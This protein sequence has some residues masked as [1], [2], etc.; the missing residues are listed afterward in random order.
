MASMAFS[1]AAFWVPRLKASP[2]PGILASGEFLATRKPFGR[3]GIGAGEVD[4]LLAVLGDAHAGHD[5]VVLLGVERRNDA[6]PILRHDLALHLHAAAE[7]AG[8]IDLEAFELAASAGEVPRR[9][10]AFRGDL[11]GLALRRRA[12]DGERRA[13]EGETDSLE[14]IHLCSLFL[15]ALL[16]RQALNPATVSG[17]ADTQ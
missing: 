1:A 4:D 13:E 3:V 14:E 16:E 9:V 12:A 5:G 10:G 7:I 17:R 11:H 6:V 15:N 2:V 8:E